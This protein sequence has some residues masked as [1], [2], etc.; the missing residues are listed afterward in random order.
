VACTNPTSAGNPQTQPQSQQ[1]S[2]KFADPGFARRW[3]HHHQRFWDWQKQQQA[4]GSTQQSAQAQDQSSQAQQ[5]GNC[6]H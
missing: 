4:P 3:H 6:D 5:G 2:A 1:V